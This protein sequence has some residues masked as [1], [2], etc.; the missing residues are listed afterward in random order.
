M[1]HFSIG[2]TRRIVR[3]K[4]PHRE[5]VS[6]NINMSSI[7]RLHGLW[8][9]QV[10][11]IIIHNHRETWHSVFSYIFFGARSLLNIFSKMRKFYKDK[12]HQ[13][14]YS[15][16]QLVYSYSKI[17]G[18]YFFAWRITIELHAWKCSCKTILNCF[19]DW[20]WNHLLFSRQYWLLVV[21]NCLFI[22]YPV[23]SLDIFFW[24]VPCSK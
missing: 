1:S 8:A 22:F 17:Y 7:G 16:V 4:R 19:A 6:E 10:W 2:S 3:R 20:R 15:N 13:C 9:S 12:L 21:I 11:C 24:G 5:S 23:S 18:K 14:N